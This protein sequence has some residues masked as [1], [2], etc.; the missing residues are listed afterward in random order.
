MISHLGRRYLLG[1]GGSS[2]GVRAVGFKEVF[3]K[4]YSMRKE[5]NVPASGVIFL[6]RLSWTNVHFYSSFF[7][8]EVDENCAPLGYYA[9]SSGNFLTTFWDNLSAPSSGFK[10]L[11]RNVGNKLPLLAA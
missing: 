11:S 5:L 3:G 2:K 10:N 8:R 1:K 9:A 7:R 4:D 6:S